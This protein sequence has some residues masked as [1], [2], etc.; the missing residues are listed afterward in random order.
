MRPILYFISILI[1][2]FIL[3]GCSSKIEP[4]WYNDFNLAALNPVRSTNTTNFRVYV[5]NQ[6]RYKFYDNKNHLIRK[7]S[8]VT[9]DG[10]KY[11][12]SQSVLELDSSAKSLYNI[13]YSKNKRLHIDHLV[14]FQDRFRLFAQDELISLDTL[15]RF[16]SRED[17]IHNDFQNIDEY[18]HSKYKEGVPFYYG[19][20]KWPFYYNKDSLFYKTLKYYDWGIAQQPDYW[21]FTNT[22]NCEYLDIGRFEFDR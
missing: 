13:S 9:Y 15:K 11:L 12:V 21:I 4:G 22:Y 19:Y 20:E 3:A 1:S 16:F 6:N 2:T 7:D 17:Y 18:I 14:E 8:V 10:T 5:D